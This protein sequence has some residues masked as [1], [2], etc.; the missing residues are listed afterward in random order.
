MQLNYMN[1]RDSIVFI[2]RAHLILIL[3]E[4]LCI[5]C[6]SS[7]DDKIPLCGLDSQHNRCRFQSHD[8]TNDIYALERSRNT[9]SLVRDLGGKFANPLPLVR[10]A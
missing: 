6:Y 1:A 10:N 9:Q 4:E 2:W 5:K 7:I 8:G 3:Q